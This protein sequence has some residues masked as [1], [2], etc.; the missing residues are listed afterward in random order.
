[1]KT[2]VIHCKLS[3]N[4]IETMERFCK[5]FDITNEATGQTVTNKSLLYV[6]VFMFLIR[7]HEVLYLGDVVKMPSKI[8]HYLNAMYKEDVDLISKV[9][10]GDT[11]FSARIDEDL[12][13]S[14]LLVLKELGSKSMTNVIKAFLNHLEDYMKR[15]KTWL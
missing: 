6:Y 11:G 3:K 10:E 2:K 5:A 4:N 14:I 1:M 15:T 13:D 12:H 7:K 8:Y 9:P